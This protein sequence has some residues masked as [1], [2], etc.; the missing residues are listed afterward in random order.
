VVSA[1]KT[2]ANRF[3]EGK[4]VAQ[5][6]RETRKTPLDAVCD[7]LL[8]EENAVTMVLFY[9]SEE[10]VKE[11][12]KNE[13]MM[14]CTDGIV[15]GKP[16]PRVYGTCAHFLGKYVREEKVLSLPQAVKRMTSFPAQR[17]RLQDRGIL[18]EGMVADIVI[19]NPD[20]IIDKGTYPEPNQYPDG[21][22][23]VLVNGEIAVDHGK[24]TS[25]RAGKV[26]RRK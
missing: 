18:R 23:Y 4:S 9:G 12:M 19:F 1:V 22:L 16:H 7:L 11:I 6:A 5:I 14:L 3:V 2:D 10:D 24:L 25:R 26:I 17:L 20:T 15:G 8:A 13:S 21:I